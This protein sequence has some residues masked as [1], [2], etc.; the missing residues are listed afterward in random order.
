MNFNNFFPPLCRSTS[1]SL[2]VSALLDIIL[3]ITF[4]NANHHMSYGET[5]LRDTV[6]DG[7]SQLRG[8]LFFPAVED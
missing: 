2:C 8:G 5:K 4:Q 3:P 6:K 7:N 1:L